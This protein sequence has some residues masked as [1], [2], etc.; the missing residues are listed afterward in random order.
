MDAPETR[1]ISFKQA[2][3]I[4]GVLIFAISFMFIKFSMYGIFYW[5]PTYL[6]DQLNFSKADAANMFSTFD[7]GS[8]VG[9]IL[10]GLI[11]DLLPYRSPVFEVGIVLSTIFTLA[12]T[13]WDNT[14]KEV[15]SIIMFFLGFTL[16]G[17]SIVIAAIECDLGKQE[18]LKHNQKA[19]ATV[20]GIIDGVAGFGSVLGQIL[21]GVIKD[22]AGWRATF[23]MLTIVTG[24]SGVPA[25]FF[26][27]NELKE[28]RKKRLLVKLK[29]IEERLKS[30][31]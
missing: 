23:L 17:S 26:M 6:R 21:I 11:T 1:S 28:W 13:F 8:I 10:M 5:L 4:P 3:L 14:S 24:L 20:S 30:N 7:A 29:V 18:I 25:F 2:L 31:D 12:L 9:N 27:R 16:T 19:L 22:S 15:L